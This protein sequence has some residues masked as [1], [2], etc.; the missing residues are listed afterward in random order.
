ME[1]NRSSDGQVQSAENRKYKKMAVQFSIAFAV[2][3]AVLL[4]IQIYLIVGRAHKSTKLDY[5]SFCAKIIEEDAGKISY[6]NEVL[7]NDL[8]IYSDSDVAK[9]G[10]AAQIIRW[11]QT[12]E[13]IRNPYFNYV[14]YCTPDGVGHMSNGKVITVASKPFYRAVMKK[15][16]KTYVSNIDFQTDGSVCYYIARPA[17]DSSGNLIGVFAGAVKLDE[18]ARMLNEL[19]IGAHGYALLAGSDGVLLAKMNGQEKYFDLLYSDKAGYSGFTDI[20]KRAASGEKGEGYIREPSG[21]N[22]FVSFCPV[23]GTPWT[24]FASVPVAQINESGNRLRNMIIIISILI[25]V[26]MVAASG[27]I[28][29][30]SMK[31]LGAVQENI[32]EIAAGEADL[33]QQLKVKSNN[34]IGALV[35]G[36]NTFISKLRMIVSGVKDSKETLAVVNNDLQARIQD[37]GTSI[38]EIIDD[39]KSIDSQVQNQAS[40][41]SETAG[42]V[43][44]ISKNIESLERMIENQSSG[45]TEASAAV[46]EMIGNI[47]SVNQSVGHMAE[48]F[49]TLS[50]KA[51]EGI[52]RQADVNDRIRKIEEQS[53]TLQ[54]A[55]KTISAIAAQ[56][57][58]LAMN[59]A[60]EAAHAGDAGRGFSVVADEI[61]KLSETSSAQSKTIKEELNKIEV[62]INEVVTASQA[63]SSSFAS[64][65][66]SIS[67]TDSLVIQIKSAME[68]QQEGSK[69]IGD[70]L[71]LMNDNTTEVRTASKE[72]AEGN[73][74]ILQEVNHLRETTDVIRDSMEKISASAGKIR[75]TSNALSDISGSVHASVD[76]I[77]NQIDL[78]KV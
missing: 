22:K 44:E 21:A 72:M 59:A 39:L 52:S 17:F 10:N 33:T 53:K 76:Q 16:Q 67:Q 3:L 5:S 50:G 18:I 73:K 62:S 34:E 69:Q 56:T 75:E 61:R 11:L 74:S 20:A 25:G 9:D 45:V 77:G 49:Q 46:E 28:I 40:S 47:G 66:D 43:E 65:S 54:D 30:R 29:F 60:I 1:E 7:V 24:A 36:F 4:S 58:L 6:W 63:S 70:A 12:H 8:R 31:P 14:M 26:A 2:G 41:V 51:Q 23:S 78:F 38:A 13:S 32:H 68:E 57:N 55:N 37:N 35:N 15:G 42:A 64:V 19:T 27:V 71:K 48:S